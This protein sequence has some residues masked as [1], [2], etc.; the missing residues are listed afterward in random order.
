MGLN[1][2]PGNSQLNE[3]AIAGMVLPS[4]ALSASETTSETDGQVIGM[5]RTWTDMPLSYRL[6]SRRRWGLTRVVP[7]IP[8]WS[9]QRWQRDGPSASSTNVII[10]GLAWV[11]VLAGMTQFGRD[12][13]RLESPIAI[14]SKSVT[15]EW[16]I[17]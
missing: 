15:G 7:N 1:V 9:A 5:L 13:A 11:L 2:C 8:A 3:P 17:H 10:R 14:E 4:R 12:V 16:R 6:R